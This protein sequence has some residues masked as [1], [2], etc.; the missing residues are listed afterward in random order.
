M[1]GESAIM[2][3]IHRCELPQEAL[4]CKYQH[5]GAYADCYVTEVSRRVSHAQYVEA[6]Y[7]TF[8]G[9]FEAF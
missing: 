4:L 6:F 9:R 1:Q 3:S 5:E 7:T 2:S 8:P